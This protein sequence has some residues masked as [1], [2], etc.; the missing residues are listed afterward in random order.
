M[1]ETCR[2][3]GAACF[4]FSFVRAFAILMPTTGGT[5]AYVYSGVFR[6]SETKIETAENGWWMDRKQAT[7]MDSRARLCALVERE[8]I[9]VH[10]WFFLQWRNKSV[11][12]SVCFVCRTAVFLLT[13][14]NCR[15]CRGFPAIEKTRHN[16][17][18]CCRYAVFAAGYQHHRT[19]QNERRRFWCM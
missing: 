18:V 4:L 19:A 16:I 9:G 17:P 12:T 6:D 3:H 14:I 1:H 8:P 5:A 7:V 13:G 2:T 10:R 11:E 15:Q